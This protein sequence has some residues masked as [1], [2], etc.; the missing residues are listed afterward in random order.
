MRSK[1]DSHIRISEVADRWVALL[2]TPRE[3]HNKVEFLGERENMADLVDKAT[4][5]GSW[6]RQRRGN[7]KGN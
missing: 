4:L 1:L 7:E 2:I 3:N 6:D 5:N